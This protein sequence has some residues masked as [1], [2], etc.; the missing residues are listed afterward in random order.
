MVSNPQG[1]LPAQCGSRAGI[2]AAYRALSYPKVRASDLMAS[3]AAATLAHI[4][5]QPPADGVIL[6]EQD[7]TTLNFTTHLALP[8]QGSIGKNSKSG[9]TGCHAHGTLLLG[10]NGYVYGMLDSEFYA[11]DDAAMEARRQAGAGK[12]N[13]EK[14]LGQGKRPLVA[15]PATQR[16]A[17]C[18]PCA[19]HLTINVADR[20]ADM[21]EL[22]KLADEL[23]ATTPQ[24]H[25][26]VR[27]QHNRKLHDEDGCLHEA[28]ASLPAQAAWE[29][30]LPAAKGLGS[31]IRKVECVWKQV[32]LEVPAH[33]RKI[34][35]AHPMPEALGH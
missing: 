28:L 33:Q 4:E 34:S 27:S 6:N 16:R 26:L 24:L 15:Q 9:V 20:E 25:L 23:R 12:R 31:Q 5:A 1:S 17:G 18:H 14:A 13:R 7:R 32:I 19:R 22:W 30:E 2:K 3:H 29:I 8:G 11:R 10:A 21:D 35:G